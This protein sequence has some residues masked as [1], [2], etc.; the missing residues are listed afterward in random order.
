MRSNARISRV[1]RS[2]RV[3][4]FGHR[5]RFFADVDHGGRS[6]ALRA[7]RAWRDKVWD[8]RHRGVKL[9]RAERSAIRKSTEHYKIVAQR[10]GISPNYVH[11]LRRA[12]GGPNERGL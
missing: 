1:H 2:W 4:V 5:P 11:K 3:R 9:T 8:G 7:A 12:R 6:A 10:Y